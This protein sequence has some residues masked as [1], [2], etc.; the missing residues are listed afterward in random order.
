MFYILNS[1]ILNLFNLLNISKPMPE[2]AAATMLRHAQQ[3]CDSPTT[4]RLG[5][6]AVV[7]RQPLLFSH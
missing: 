3:P 2:N 5:C 7:A 1:F 6:R 4:S